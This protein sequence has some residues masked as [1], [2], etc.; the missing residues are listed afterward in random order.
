VYALN[1]TKYLLPHE[2]NAF[3]RLIAQ[4]ASRDAVLLDVLLHTGG[5]AQEVLNLNV[6][7]LNLHSGT[8]LIRGLKGSRDR[9]IPLPMALLCRLESIL[10]ASGRIFPISYQRLYQIW[11]H[12]KP[13]KK[14]LHS[15]RHTFAIELYR[16]TR[17]LRLVQMALGHKSIN[18]TMVY[19]DY[20]YTQEELKKLLITA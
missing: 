18:N 6:E 12:W 9:E 7:D 3:Q 8:V 10:P 16:R 14:K 17:D 19:A 5:R 15:L 1:Q 2:L 13:C 4:D 11:D 20:I